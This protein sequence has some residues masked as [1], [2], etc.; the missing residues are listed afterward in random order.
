MDMNKWGPGEWIGVIT[1]LGVLITTATTSIISII[2]A[3]RTEGKMEAL[4]GRITSQADTARETRAAVHQLARDM[5][6]PS[7]SVAGSPVVGQ[8]EI[9]NTENH[10]VPTTDV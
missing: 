7:G 10:P 9:V 8:V 4:D 3:A 5:P 1:A 6:P 2:R